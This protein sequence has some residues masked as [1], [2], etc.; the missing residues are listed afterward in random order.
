MVVYSVPHVVSG[1]PWLQDSA[2]P[3]RLSGLSSLIPAGYTPAPG[4]VRAWFDDVLDELEVRWPD[5]HV[6]L[7]RDVATREHLEV[8]R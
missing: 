3:K 1:A 7:Y 6:D 2:L 4:Q 5:G 8:V